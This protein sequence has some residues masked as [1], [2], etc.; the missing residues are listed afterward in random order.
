[1][2]GQRKDEGGDGRARQSADEEGWREGK[3]DVQLLLGRSGTANPTAMHKQTDNAKKEKGKGA[4]WRRRLSTEEM[5]G[6]TR[7]NSRD[8]IR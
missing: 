2:Q 5:K 4:R 7:S 6:L 8:S 1:M 3:K